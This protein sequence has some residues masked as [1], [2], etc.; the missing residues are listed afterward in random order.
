MRILHAIVLLLFTLIPPAIY[1]SLDLIQPR[2]VCLVLIAF[3]A[4]RML[5]SWT[6]NSDS[7]AIMLWS[8]FMIAAL[9]AIAVSDSAFALLLYPVVMN[10]GFLI[11]FLYSLVVPPSM[12]EK[13]AR[14]HDADLPESG[15]CYTRKVTMVWSVF[16]LFNGCI[17][18]WT[19]WRGD[20]A[21]WG[22]YNGLIAY[23]LMGTLMIAEYGIRCRVRKTFENE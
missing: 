10:I 17:A 13:I 6:L 9:F 1:F 22:L 5:S 23:L 11:L 7:S 19:V 2:Y 16:F 21:L 4:L 18:A 3:F 15:V 14:L 12:I 20:R 8:L